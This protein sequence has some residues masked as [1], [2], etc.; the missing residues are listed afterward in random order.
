MFDKCFFSLLF[1]DLIFILQS[2]FRVWW[3]T[4]CCGINSPLVQ[5]LNDGEGKDKDEP[6]L[7][8]LLALSFDLH[9]LETIA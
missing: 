7:V 1:V 2:S 4:Q 6:G 3:S 5:E 9:L 8:T